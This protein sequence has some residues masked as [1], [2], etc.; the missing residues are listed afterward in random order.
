MAYHVY[1]K[2]KNQLVDVFNHYWEAKDLI[3]LLDVPEGYT[4]RSQIYEIRDD[5]GN[6]AVEPEEEKK[7]FFIGRIT[8]EGM[9]EGFKPESV[10][11]FGEIFELERLAYFDTEADAMEA[12]KKYTSNKIRHKAAFE[13]D[14]IAAEQFFVDTTNMNSGFNPV[15]AEYAEKEYD[16]RG[17]GVYQH[18]DCYGE[19]QAM[20][21]WT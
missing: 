1:F 8:F 17:E 11:N 18:Y 21:R 14:L 13:G 2:P 10:N 5:D 19:L 7:P 4:F 16:F 9:A 15:V 20:G 12:L 6:V 3:P